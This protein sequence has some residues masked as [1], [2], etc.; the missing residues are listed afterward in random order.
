MSQ[1]HPSVGSAPSREGATPT[2]W[3]ACET[4]LRFDRVTTPRLVLRR[5]QPDDLDP[6]AALNADP[7]VMR[8]FPSTYE[9]AATAT[10]IT[11][12]EA[13]IDHQGFGLWAVERVQDGVLLGMAGLNPVPPGIITGGGL[14]VGWRLARH[15]WGHGYA[16]E[17]GGAAIDV[18]RQVGADSVWSFTAVGNERSQAVMRRLGLTFVRTFDHP[19]IPEG[20]PVRPHVLYR[21]HLD[22]SGAA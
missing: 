2:K 8:Y 19:T 10:T 7:E 16:T 18:A 22:L 4:G 13:K 20:H 9:R 17:A 3:C 14:E 12:W 11:N 6:F 5:W 15:A 1:P 21:R